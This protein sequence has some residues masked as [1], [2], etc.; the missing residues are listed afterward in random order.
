MAS[1][2]FPKIVKIPCKVTN[3]Y[4]S[5]GLSYICQVIAHIAPIKLGTIAKLKK[6]NDLNLLNELT[7]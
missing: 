2:V 6:K 1:V 4:S 7:S 5:E 3:P